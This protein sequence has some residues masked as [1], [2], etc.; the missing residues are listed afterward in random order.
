VDARDKPGHDEPFS[1]NPSSH[2]SAVSTA[3]DGRRPAC[4]ALADAQKKT[5]H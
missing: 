5:R 4:Y 2:I 1:L 3:G